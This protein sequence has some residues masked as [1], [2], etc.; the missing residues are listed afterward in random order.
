MAKYNRLKIGW[1]DGKKELH[2]SSPFGPRKFGSHTYHYG[3]D[4]AVPVGTKILAP[5][6]GK[7]TTMGI[8]GGGAG[9]YCTLESGNI[10]LRFMHLSWCLL[11]ESRGR[12]MNV[13]EGNLIAKTGGAKGNRLSGSSTG[14]HLHFEYR[15]STNGSW[16][17]ND[18]INPIFVLSE[19]LIGRLN[20]NIIS[21]GSKQFEQLNWLEKIT[22]SVSNVYDTQRGISSNEKQIIT[23]YPG[24]YDPET[25]TIDYGWDIENGV[26]RRGYS[27]QNGGGRVKYGTQIL[28]VGDGKPMEEVEISEAEMADSANW[29]E[30]YLTDDDATEN[31]S[32]EPKETVEGKAKGIW[33]IVKLAMDGN[34]SDKM[35]FDAS[36][37]AQT[38]SILGFFNK[39]C[40]QP[41]V[42]FSGDTFGDQYYFLVRRPPFD[43]EGI[44]KALNIQ[45]LLEVDVLRL[46]E[47]LAELKQ[48]SGYYDPPSAESEQDVYHWKQKMDKWK[49]KYGFGTDYWNKVKKLEEDI[50]N[51]IETRNEY[52]RHSNPYVIEKKDIVNSNISFNTQGIYSWYQFYPQYELAGD[53]MQ[54]IVPA[55]MF[56]EYA[57]VWGSRPLQIQSQYASFKGLGTRD[58]QK[59]GIK[60]EASDKRCRSI[61]DD[62][63]YLI[64]SNAYNPFVRQ[65]TI[66]LV[67]IRRIKRG[68]FVDVCVESGVPEIFYVEGVSHSYSI[69]GNAISDTT[70]LQLSHGMVKKYIKDSNK[71][72]GDISYF[73]LIEFKDYEKNRNNLNIGNWREVIS[74]W[75]V[76]KEVFK[77]FLQKKQ[78]IKVGG[79]TQFNF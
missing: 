62:L 26:Y 45:H 44:L 41:L 14:P 78:F 57:A 16:T 69:T 35:V 2:I 76:N 1:L 55:V 67:G 47:K 53:K 42:E 36:I 63:K 65:G 40:Q 39:A 5:F 22:Q 13:S 28:Q 23:N 30:S 79:N 9:L 71:T 66:T 24:N 50:R 54:Y 49:R 29:N 38:G 3:I 4:I 75:A 11:G 25:D 43:K 31:L 21:R 73:D 58:A 8:G 32:E 15:Y 72:N 68:M 61:L 46:E 74:H 70:T 51:G 20:Q 60:D 59:N 52:L 12:T 33:Q 34:V 17:K 37:S 48:N 19:R 6:S 18:A 27:R 56:P 64:E 77:F 10:Q 7:L